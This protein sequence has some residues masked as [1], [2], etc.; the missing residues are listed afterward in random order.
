MS[1]LMHECKVFTS[2]LIMQVPNAYVV[3][4]Y[5]AGHMISNL[6]CEPR[7]YTFDKMLVTIASRHR[8]LTRLV[9]SY[10][11]VVFPA[12][13]VRRKLILLM[14]ILESC[15]PTH[16]EF[17][18]GDKTRKGVACIR[19]WEGVATFLFN[20]ALSMLF[21]GPLHVIF[22]AKSILRGQG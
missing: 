4:K 13:V 19:I 10:S 18:V 7:P 2:Y 20:V 17:E 3:E 12:S 1:T 6:H 5:Q 9:D 22:V 15:S 21:L 8:F 14:A 16:E 11:R